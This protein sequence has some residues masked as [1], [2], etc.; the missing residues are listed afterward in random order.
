MSSSPV[1]ALK[2][3]RGSIAFVDKYVKNKTTMA[4]FLNQIG[5]EGM[6]FIGI[7]HPFIIDNAM[8]DRGATAFDGTSV[9]EINTR[10]LGYQLYRLYP[11]CLGKGRYAPDSCY[12]PESGG[13]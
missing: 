8:L 3:S 5:N 13:Y 2:I 11:P 1:T 6:D 4:K 12:F 9:V 7:E 10:R